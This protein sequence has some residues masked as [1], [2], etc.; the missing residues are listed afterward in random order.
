MD[1]GTHRTSSERDLREQAI[2]DTRD[3]TTR[4]PA[5][6]R[7]GQDR[8]FELV[9]RSVTAHAA[10]TMWWDSGILTYQTYVVFQFTA[11]MEP[12]HEKLPVPRK[13]LRTSGESSIFSRIPCKIIQKSPALCRALSFLIC[14]D[15]ILEPTRPCASA[16]P[17]FHLRR[18]HRHPFLPT[19]SSSPRGSS[20]RSRPMRPVERSPSSLRR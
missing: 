6:V 2:W 14:L 8:K 11:K 19:R 9:L 10:T 17:L 15:F 1:T 4:R 13:K 18:S 3:A 7:K 5:V 12:A 16:V 20:S